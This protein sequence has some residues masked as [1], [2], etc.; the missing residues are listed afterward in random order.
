MKEVGYFLEKK[1]TTEAPV[2]GGRNY[3]G[4]KVKLYSLALVKLNYMLETPRKLLSTV[5][6]R[7]SKNLK[8]MGTISREDLVASISTELSKGLT[9]LLFKWS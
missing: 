7:D 2:N 1:L 3:D 5:F 4:P 8:D 9:N 6:F